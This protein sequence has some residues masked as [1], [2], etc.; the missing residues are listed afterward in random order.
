[1]G[2]LTIATWRAVHNIAASFLISTIVRTIWIW[3]CSACQTEV[4]T[5]YTML[6]III[7][8]PMSTHKKHKCTTSQ[9]QKVNKTIKLRA[10]LGKFSSLSNHVNNFVHLFTLLGST[11]LSWQVAYWCMCTPC[12]STSCSLC[13]KAHRSNYRSLHL[14]GQS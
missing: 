3:L 7:T 5:V 8:C 2:W 12:L 10:S 6:C 4:Y 1:M 13:Q 11:W 9:L 14:E